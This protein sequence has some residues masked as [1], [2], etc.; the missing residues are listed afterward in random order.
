MAKVKTWNFNTTDGTSVEVSLRK[1][2]WISVNGGE[3]V[4]A[5]KIKNKEDSNAFETVFDIALPN[6][7]VAKLFCSTT[8]KHL[9]YNGKD[10]NTGE[11]Y[12]VEKIPGWEWVFIVLYIVNFAL[13][14]GG[15]LGAVVNLFA[16]AASVRIATRSKKSTGMKVL[17]SILLFVGV[18]VLSLL[19]AGVVA[20]LLA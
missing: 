14:L 12:E 7:E 9:V 4:H 20:G 6:G 15:A 11:A 19:V 3:E 2:T 8:Q 17:L 10:V 16:A 5:K 13:I 18:L 1:N